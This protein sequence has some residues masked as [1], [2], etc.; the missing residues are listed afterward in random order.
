MRFVVFFFCA[1]LACAQPL[2][3]EK[4]VPLP[5]V[6]GRIDHLAMDVKTQRLLLSALGN[7]TVEVVDVAAGKIVHSL[8]GMNEP[9][10]TSYVPAVN[11]MYVAN[12]KDGKLR[13]YDA[14]S[15]R[16]AG[17]VGFGEDA[18]NVRYDAAHK[19]LWVGYAD[20][21]LSAVDIA[22]AKRVKDIYLDGHPE[23]F[24]LEK[25]GPRIFANVPDAR[26][27]R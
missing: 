26:D 11:K 13:I 9:Q 2:Q 24:Q 15:Y 27:S 6:E 3:L 16:P 19:W 23:S 8:P 18:D 17:E 12:G 21:G 4:T 20:G 22:T 7:N 25:N 1:A 5:G 14:A 10:G